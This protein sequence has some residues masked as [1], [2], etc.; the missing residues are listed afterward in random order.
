L[1]VA[2]LFLCGCEKKASGPDDD[3]DGGPSICGKEMFISFKT[4]GWSEKIDC[5]HLSFAPN[6]GSPPPNNA[7]YYITATSAST[8]MSFQIGYPADSSAVNRLA[9]GQRFL[10]RSACEVLKEA[11]S[12]LVIVP[13]SKGNINRWAPV[14]DVNEKS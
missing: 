8:K 2:T 7:I 3:S 13:E 5:S 6:S 4:P 10:Q 9:M 1:V 12:L 11:V 14:P